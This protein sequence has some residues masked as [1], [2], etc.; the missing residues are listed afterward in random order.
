MGYPY[1]LSNLFATIYKG[2]GAP[3]NIALFYWVTG[4]N[5]P[6]IFLE[7]GATKILGSKKKHDFN[8]QSPGVSHDYVEAAGWADFACKLVNQPPPKHKTVLSLQK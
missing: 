1:C 6:P 2:Y 8:H 5:T 4:Q 7:P 3:I